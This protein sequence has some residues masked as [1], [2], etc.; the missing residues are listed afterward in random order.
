MADELTKFKDKGEKLF[1]KGKYKDAVA[2]YEKIAPYGNKD[3][4]IFMRTGDIARKIPDIPKAVEYYS[5]A[6]NAYIKQGFIIKAIAICK[7]ILSIDP[8]QTGM[9]EK[10]AKL[11]SEQGG[12]S[13][14]HLG[15]TPG[16]STVKHG[17]GAVSQEAQPQAPE[18]Q[19]PE[20]QVLE[21]QAPEAFESGESV[22][23]LETLHPVSQ[24][25]SGGSKQS[26]GET[27]KRTFPRTLLFSDFTKEELFAV[28]KRV[29]FSEHRR[30]ETLFHEG[31]KGDSIYIIVSGTVDISSLAKD[32]VHVLI[33][34][35][36]E[37]EFFGEF[38][39]FSDAGRQTTVAV[40][41]DA[42][43]L[44]LKK[45]DMDEIVATHPRASEVMFAFY[46]DRVVD[47]L[48][49]LSET[50]RPMS[51]EDRKQVLARLS[52]QEYAKGQVIMKQGDIGD[53][54]YLVKKGKA[55]VFVDDGSGGKTA[56]AELGDGE[57]FGEIALATNK[58]RTASVNALSGKLELVVFSRPMIKDI[59][60]KYPAIKDTL[61]G[62]IKERVTDLHEKSRKPVT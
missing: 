60:E 55:E 45:A 13:Q 26:G 48:M 43:F 32:G 42:E 2:A 19:A 31:D 7:M 37:G 47:R 38:S 22:P 9:E 50:F 39:F 44:E 18:P 25:T 23:E 29:K 46:K 12:E 61:L 8:S 16:R 54:M 6:S 34:T 51:E 56:L 53:T 21:P 28:V 49:A 3:P 17:T 1:G 62:V 10:L 11:Y 33:D 40:R 30:G 59:L 14:A 15:A 52:I 36:G 58:P 24:A 20:P 41:E 27:K 4:H 57:F 5:Y 35:L